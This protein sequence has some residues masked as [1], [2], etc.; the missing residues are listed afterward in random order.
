VNKI[1]PKADMETG[2]ISDKIKRGKHTTRHSEIIYIQE[3]TYI[4]D[5]PGFSSLYVSDMEKEEL[6][7]YFMEFREYEDS[8]RFQGCVHIN[9]PGCAVKDALKSGKISAIRYENYSI[10]YEELK[11]VKKY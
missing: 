6:K 5:T 3:G 10:L 8:C 2:E 11:N 7:N 4:C 9:E 1:Q